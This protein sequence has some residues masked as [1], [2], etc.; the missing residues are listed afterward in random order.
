LGTGWARSPGL[1]GADELWRQDQ[2][3]DASAHFGT[4][5]STG[6]SRNRKTSR[7]KSGSSRLTR[8]ELLVFWSMITRL[9]EYV[10]EQQEPAEEGSENTQNT[11]KPPT[12]MKQP[13]KE[14]YIGDCHSSHD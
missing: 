12:L 1:Y 2:Y 6:S 4:R 5:P 9:Q 11:Q 3:T 8:C 13:H 10:T 14:K 7:T